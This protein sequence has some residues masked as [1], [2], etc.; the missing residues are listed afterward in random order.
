MKKIKIILG[1][2]TLLII[3]FFA[4]GLI[5]KE[6]NYIA[7]ISVNKSISDTFTA[8]NNL[9][10]LKKWVPEIKSYK[11]TH[12]NFGKAGSEYQ[13]VI[14]NNGQ[15]LIISERI[16]AYVPNKKVTLF[17]DAE[18][19]LKTNDYNFVEKNGKTLITLHASCSSDSY[20]L[21][22]IFPYFKGIFKKQDQTYLHNFKTFIEQ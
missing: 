20:I 12:Q 19:M 22:C 16:M 3:V 4:T 11:V 5:V 14:D 15:D 8:F 21:S 10:N 7:K 2:I 13:M 17:Y 1:I 18:N 9:E 6:T